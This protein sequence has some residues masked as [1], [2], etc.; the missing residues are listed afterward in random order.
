[1]NHKKFRFPKLRHL[2]VVPVIVSLGLIT[3]CATGTAKADGTGSA[4]KSDQATQQNEEPQPGGNLRFALVSAPVGVD[5]Q[6]V[7][8]NVSIYIARSLVDSLT[9]QDPK[10]G[11]IVPWLAQSWEINPDHSEFTF[12]LRDDVTFSDGSALT[13]QVVKD[14]LDTIVADL[15]AL[16]PLANGYLSGYAS[17][18]VVDEHTVTVK[19]TEPNAQ[20]LQATSTLSLG[21]VSAET[22][23]KTPEERNQGAVVG[24]GPFVLESYTQDQGAKIVRRDGYNWASESFDH[25]GEAYLDSVDFSVVPESGVRAGGLASGQFDAIGDALPQD[26]AQIEAAQGSILTRSNPGV[27]FVLQFNTTKTPVESVAVRKAIILGVNRQELVDTVLSDQFLPA[28]SVLAANTPGYLDLS[29][30]LAFD[31]D[32]ALSLLAADGWE[33]GEDGLQHKNGQ[34]L[35]VET[36]YAPLFSGNQAILELT[37]QQLRDIGVD[38]QLRQQTAAQQGETLTSGDYGATYFN[39]T[40]AEADILRNFFDTRQR[41]WSNL[42]P[43]SPLDALFAQSLSEPDPVKR[44][45]LLATIQR[46]IVDQAYA[47]PLFELAQS[48]GVAKDVR[49][50]G[51]EASSRLKFYDAWLVQ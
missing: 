10:T 27:P 6:Q 40:R 14:N 19:F 21:I 5:P 2:A 18:D 23:T 45:E 17:T 26:V 3:A 4:K 11:E 28:T 15:G 9:D 48:I 12:H 37:Q 38:L 30:D 51:F 33:L 7:S 34:T 35:T 32:Q 44:A 42:A 31:P 8:T 29:A 49:G 43:D 47:V 50:L 22:L 46:E 20:F 39:S 25:Q 36:V 16:A 24:T 1:M 41:N 13:A